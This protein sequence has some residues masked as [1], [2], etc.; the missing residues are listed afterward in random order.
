MDKKNIK[1]LV[2]INNKTV[3]EEIVNILGKKK[4]FEI[5]TAVDSPSALQVIKSPDRYDA[6]VIDDSF[7]KK[8]KQLK[9]L[10]KIKKDYPDIEIILIA[11][12]GDESDFEAFKKASIRCFSIPL[13]FEELSLAFELLCIQVRYNHKRKVSDIL[14]KISLDIDSTTEMQ[15]IMDLTCK[16]AVDILNVDHSGLV[17]FEKDFSKGI[18]YAE[19]PSELRVKGKEIPIRGVSLEETLINEK[20]IIVIPDVNRAKSLK[21]KSSSPLKSLLQEFGILS[22]LFIPVVLN[23][24][25]IASFSLDM[26]SKT[27]KFYDDE[28]ELCRKF[29]SLVAVAVGKARYVNELSVLNQVGQTLSKSAAL[30]IDEILELIYKQTGRLMDV[31][32]FY[33]AFYY[34]EEDIIRFKFVIESGK[35]QDLGKEDYEDRKAGKGL[36]EYI[37]H[38]KKPLLIKDNV[39]KFFRETLYIEKKG[40]MAHSWLGAPLISEAEAMGVIGV[41]NF[42]RENVYDE[43]DMEVLSTISSQAAIA[44]K[45]ARLLQEREL[46]YKELKALY[47]TSLQITQQLELE[48]LL[49]I[50]VKRAAELLDAPS[51]GLM[52]R[53]GEKAELEMKFTHN[54]DPMLGVRF[55]FGQGLVGKVA[56]SGKPMIVNDYHNWVGRDVRF[57]EPP[58]NNLFRALAVVP[59]KWQEEVIGVL[60][61]SD[62]A[63]HRVFI[64]NDI[65]ILERFAN[66]AAI[67]YQNATLFNIKVRELE[68]LRQA[69]IALLSTM[70]QD[71]MLK[72][73]LDELS[74]FVECDLYVIR[75]WDEEQREL[76]LGLTKGAYPGKIPVRKNLSMGIS[77]LA[78][79][80]RKKIVSIN[81]HRDPSYKQMLKGIKDTEE[82]KY[83]HWIGSEAAV[84]LI[85]KEQLVGVLAAIK[86]TTKGF[87]ESDIR[88]VE[89]FAGQA[90]IALHNTRLIHRSR[91]YTTLVSHQLRGPLQAIRGDVDFQIMYIE[92]KYAKDDELNHV[93]RRLGEHFGKIRKE[94]DNFSFL[95]RDELVGHHRYSMQPNFI[96]HVIDESS[97]QFRENASHRG[98]KISINDN[99]RS[100]PQFKFDR[101]N[102]FTVFTNLIENA[103]KYSHENREVIIESV[104]EGCWIKINV[105]DYGLGILLEDKERIFELYTQ[106]KLKDERRFVQGTGIGLWVVRQ[107]I[108]AHGGDIKVWSK[109]FD[110]QDTGIKEELEKKGFRTD[111][112]VELPI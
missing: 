95:I 40:K 20:Q 80:L 33:I 99:I 87:K 77:G 70:G 61:I 21:S 23:D 71:E 25:V 89:I 39:E 5:E 82:Q 58:Y 17:I 16:A 48:P 78:A 74:K 47:D 32:N 75:F 97:A 105:S 84:P 83:L 46:R 36:T 56:Q 26:T 18:V 29:A 57:N 64:D 19:Y 85:A 41:Q 45:N 73:I 79:Y 66:Q 106:G 14:H 108:K 98:I 51:G 11:T 88:L 38:T 3:Q 22:C 44:I 31:R 101:E 37:I 67:A 63:E 30:N 100:I 53:D 6:V 2:A 28:I 50:I 69:D 109:L 35:K 60:A 68:A 76:T 54:L 24:K 1:V 62:I 7:E 27:R 86:H 10:K 65:K 81:V 92:K 107:I 111:I 55:K 43:R 4:D 13:R 103:V 8:N 112:T 72:T 91:Q 42:E 104:R 9:L 49:K 94:L 90:A 52:L 12:S 15:E 59:L 34:S 93:N 102:M 110:Y 96:H